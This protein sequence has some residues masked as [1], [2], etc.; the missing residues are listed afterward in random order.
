MRWKGVN[1]RSRSASGIP[2]T[3]EDSAKYGRRSAVVMH[4]RTII[5]HDSSCS[6]SVSPSR[7]VIATQRFTAEMLQSQCAVSDGLRIW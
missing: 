7:K 5:G 1:T 3:A 6:L 2:L 4:S